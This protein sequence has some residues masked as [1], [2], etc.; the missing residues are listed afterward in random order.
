MF[1]VCIQMIFHT[2]KMRLMV[3]PHDIR[4]KLFLW[5]KNDLFFSN[6][7]A[8]R[9]AIRWCGCYVLLCSICLG[10]VQLIC[11]TCKAKQFINAFHQLNICFAFLSFVSRPMHYQL[12][13]CLDKHMRVWGTNHGRCIYSDVLGRIC[14][15]AHPLEY[16]VTH[17]IQSLSW[18][19]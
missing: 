18:Q 7:L 11:M 15:G 10:P 6:P 8:L 5:Y 4:F 1:K 12:D 2:E 9:A 13:Q 17:Y 3:T 19:P 16:V 14:S